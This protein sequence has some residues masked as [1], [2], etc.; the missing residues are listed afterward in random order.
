MRREYAGSDA[1]GRC[2]RFFLLAIIETMRP[3]I[4][5]VSLPLGFIKNKKLHFLQSIESEIVARSEF[6][7]AVAEGFTE[8][9]ERQESPHDI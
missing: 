8:E 6:E 5:I 9:G 4:R 2:I 1:R 7:E 3:S